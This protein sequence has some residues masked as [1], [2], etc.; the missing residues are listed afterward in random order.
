MSYWN[1]G[2]NRKKQQEMTRAAVEQ[3]RQKSLVPPKTPYRD[4]YSG[5]N[6]GYSSSEVYEQR[7]KDKFAWR[8]GFVIIGFVFV[9]GIYTIYWAFTT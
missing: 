9:A 2:Y 5:R 1:Q 4:I 8:V 6:L 3:E 7:R